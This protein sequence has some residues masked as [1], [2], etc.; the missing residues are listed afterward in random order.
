MVGWMEGRRDDRTDRWMD[1]QTG[2]LMG[3][4]LGF[5][6]LVPLGKFELNLLPPHMKMLHW[7]LKWDPTLS[8]RAT[9]IVSI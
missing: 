1:G 3:V 7:G 2:E 8:P 4:D 9:H 5:L 6:L